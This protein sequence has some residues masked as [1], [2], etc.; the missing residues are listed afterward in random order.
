MRFTN[1]EQ[2]DCGAMHYN[3]ETSLPYDIEGGR[4]DTA[5]W[6]NPTWAYKDYQAFYDGIGICYVSHSE[7]EAMNEELTNLEAL[8]LNLKP[9]EEGYMTTEQYEEARG[10]YIET[11]GETRRSIMDKVREMCAEDYLL[12]EKQIEHIAEFI[13][14]EADGSS[15][16]SCLLDDFWMEDDII[17]D[18]GMNFYT[19]LQYDAVMAGKLPREYAEARQ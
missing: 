10:R 15:I 18:A 2:K 13:L 7:L 5:C 16:T 6:D 19:E 9:G 17:A 1:R 14:I 8:Y 11:C 3:P 4:I 12:T